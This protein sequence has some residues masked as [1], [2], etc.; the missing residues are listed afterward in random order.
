[1]KC[2]WEKEAEKRAKMHALTADEGDDTA[3]EDD[4]DDTE[5]APRMGFAL[6]LLSCRPCE[7]QK[8]ET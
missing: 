5:G 8:R 3:S 2:A 4:E 1:M 7:K 6:P